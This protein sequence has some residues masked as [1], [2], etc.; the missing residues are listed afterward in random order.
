MPLIPNSNNK[1]PTNSDQILDKP[2]MQYQ[3]SLPIYTF[4]DLILDDT[5]ALLLSSEQPAIDT[6]RTA[7]KSAEK[8]FLFI[9]LTSL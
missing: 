3:K 5:P 2:K 8:I 1:Q 4:D 6:D 9:I 7:A